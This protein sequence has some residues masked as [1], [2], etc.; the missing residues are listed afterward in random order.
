MT[1]VL[2][3]DGGNPLIEEG[4]A[5]IREASRFLGISRAKLYSLMDA[6]EL[7]YA[8]L[9]KSRRIPW[10]AIKELAERSMVVR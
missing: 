3:N 9:G 4:L 1:M 2:S 10:R 7:A 6:G 8:K 5:T